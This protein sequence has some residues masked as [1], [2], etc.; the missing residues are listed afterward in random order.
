MD[1]HTTAT[2]SASQ[3]GTTSSLDRGLGLYL[4]MSKARLGTL[5]V[6]T[7]VAGYMLAARGHASLAVMAWTAIGTTLTAFG[8]AI[9]NQIAEADRDRR[10]LRTGNRPLPSGRVSPATAMRWGLVSSLVGLVVLAVGANLLT[11]GLALGVILLYV[12]VYTPLKVRTPLNTIVGAVCGAVPPVMGWTA[13]TGQLQAGAGILFAV[14]FVWQ[15]PHFLALAWLYRADYA[16]G[17][18]CMLPAVDPSGRTVGTVAVVWTLALIPIAALATLIGITGTTSL[19][20]SLILGVAFLRLGWLFARQ[21]TDRAARRLFLA[22]VIYLPLALGL[23]VSDMDDRLANGAGALL[24]R[25]SG[26]VAAASTVPATTAPSSA[27][28]AAGVH[29]PPS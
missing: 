17:G 16:R 10:M 11:A 27:V 28:G 23:M 3:G 29:S 21:R 18:F 22:S 15:I 6:L 9:F 19:T 12:L 13:A 8:A 1:A 4:E 25:R 7:T 14:L 26:P 5:V 2:L 24:A 20:G